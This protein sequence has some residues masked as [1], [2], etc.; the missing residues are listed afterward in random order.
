MGNTCG[1]CM[2]LDKDR[3][4][5]GV[6][7]TKYWC[8][9]FQCWRKEDQGACDA[10]VGSGGCFLTSACVEERGL[11][12]DCKELTLLRYFRDEYMK[13]TPEGAKLV[14]EYYA[15]APGIVEKINQRPD[16]KEIYDSI[17]K[18]IITCV[19][20]IEAKQFEETL[21]IYASMV[22]RVQNI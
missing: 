20:L 12:D 6:F 16:K 13:K 19:G 3:K 5:V 7:S 17:Y 2:A 4:E 9:Q 1:G 8:R 11:P 14:E 15:I 22:K 21:A 10:Y 18:D